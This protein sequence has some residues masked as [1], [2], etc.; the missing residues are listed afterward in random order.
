[1]PGKAVLLDVDVQVKER[2]EDGVELEGIMSE[3]CESCAHR[4]L[5]PQSVAMTANWILDGD[6]RLDSNLDALWALSLPSV[7]TWLQANDEFRFRLLDT[8]RGTRERF[9]GTSFELDVVTAAMKI[10]PS[11]EAPVLDLLGL[12]FFRE[13]PVLLGDCHWS[14]EVLVNSL[15]ESRCRAVMRAMRQRGDYTTLLAGMR[16][17]E[18]HATGRVKSLTARLLG[19]ASNPA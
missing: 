6:L 3:S 18:K 1:M 2:D 4:G 19:S 5:A 11:E 7:A 14:I 12:L 13:L 17:A 16:Y 15:T 10:D 8:L 9:A